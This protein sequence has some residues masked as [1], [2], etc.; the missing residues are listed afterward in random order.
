MK[1][2]NL[3]TVCF[4]ELKGNFVIPPFQR[5]Y[6]WGEEATRLLEDIME[7]D[8]GNN[9]E[10]YCLQPV[11]VKKIG[12]DKFELIDGQQRLT[13]LFLIHKALIRHLNYLDKEPEFSIDYTIRKNTKTFL[14]NLSEKSDE[15]YIDFYFIKKAF[16]AICSW[17]DKKRQIQKTIEHDFYSRLSQKVDIIWY[18]VDETEDSNSLF[19]RLNIGQIPLTN[20][21][22]VKAI[23]L[24]EAGKAQLGTQASQ[25]IALQWDGIEKR[26]E[27]DSLW[28]FLSGN[29]SLNHKSRIDLVLDLISDNDD[30]EKYHTFFFFDK[31]RK[32]PNTDLEK[33][34]ESIYYTFSVLLDWYYDHTFYHLIGFLV[35]IGKSLS[36]IYKMAEGKTKTEFSNELKKCVIR[37]LDCKDKNISELNYENDSDRKKI[38]N[39]LLL[40]NVVSTAN[41]EAGKGRFPFDKYWEEDWSLEHIHA[42]HSEGMN[43]KEE[44]KEWLSYHIPSVKALGNHTELINEMNQC[45]SDKELTKIQ[46]DSIRKK[47]VDCLSENDNVGYLHTIANLALL[48]GADNSALNNS[49]FD[50]KRNK[51]I[52][53]DKEGCFIPLCTRRVFLKYYSS[54]EQG[55]IHF[56]GQA[57]R[58]SYIRNINDTLKEY[59]KPIG[60]IEENA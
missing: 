2:I 41:S 19:Q 3:C 58:E 53:M 29:N 54:S 23:F 38:Q 32:E 50:V 18:E 6:R 24:C 4:S 37:E 55:Q 1:N 21:E 49:T 60:K 42:Q 39:I 26:L 11:V 13:T 22:L 36:S 7:I 28:V 14:E 31:L 12:N 59:I 27:D 52:N 45:Y 47:V 34:W 46:F 9:K 48:S 30:D 43:H 17:F 5:G 35:Y 15:S 25:E 16:L 56:W 20:S 44:W 33:I 8:I 10:R 51:I 40:F 57:D